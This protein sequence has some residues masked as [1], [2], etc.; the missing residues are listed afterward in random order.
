MADVSPILVVDDHS[1]IRTEV[2]RNLNSA[3]FQVETVSSGSEAFEKFSTTEYSLVIAD[4]Q[5][6]GIDGMD[7]LNSVKKKYH[8]NFR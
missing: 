7:L 6:S 8:R 1:D 4:E 5:I 3:G 2:S